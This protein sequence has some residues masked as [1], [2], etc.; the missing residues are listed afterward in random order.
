MRHNAP[1][2]HALRPAEARTAPRRRSSEGI[3]LL[4]LALIT[5][6][7]WLQLWNLTILHY[8][9]VAACFLSKTSTLSA[10]AWDCDHSL[11]TLAY[12][13]TSATA[14]TPLL[15]LAL[16]FAPPGASRAAGLRGLALLLAAMLATAAP[17]VT[18][19]AA[20]RACAPLAAYAASLGLA[21]GVL[22]VVMYVP[23]IVATAKARGSASLSYCFLWLH[24]VLGAG[25]AVQKRDGTHERVLTWAPP[26][27]ANAM[28][29]ILICMN[30]YYDVQR[31]GRPCDVADDAGED[32]A[33]QGEETPLTGGKGGGYGAAAA[34]APQASTCVLVRFS[35]KWWLRYL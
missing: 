2:K 10:G 3:S 31:G 20:A 29:L 7:F 32:D 1:L 8:D 13:V 15:P 25:A 28:Q 17:A 5:L 35:R 16:Y 30:L 4:T 33:A 24:C 6:G 11:T 23:Q 26:L 21:C 22:Y 12:T 14:A 18:G 19:L 9:Q 34:D 27:V